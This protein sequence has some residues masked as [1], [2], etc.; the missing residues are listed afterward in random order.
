M[1]V[2]ATIL[3][4]DFYVDT[5]KGLCQGTTFEF[6]AWVINMDLPRICGGNPILPNITFNIET[7]TGTV[8]QTINSGIIPTN[9][10]IVWKQY[11]LYFQT[12]AGISDVVIRMKNNAPG[13]CGND[14]ALDDITFRPCGPLINTSA[15]GSGNDSVIN[16]CVGDTSTIVLT[17]Q[18]SGGYNSPQYQWQVSTDSGTA[19]TDIP[20]A[21]S[22][23]Y[24]RL[25][26]PAGKYLYR[27]AVAQ[28]GNIG[29]TT[30]RVASTPITV[31]VNPNPSPTLVNLGPKCAGSVFTLTA[32][33]GSTYTWTGP[34]NFTDTGQ[35]ITIANA[36]NAAHYYVN[37][38][39]IYGC[40]A[41]DSTV[42]TVYAN[43]VAKF[44]AATPDCE[45]KAIDFTDQSNVEP[46]ETI[47]QLKWLFGDGTSS[48]VANPQHT[49]S[50]ATSYSDS[51]IVTT[52]KGCTDTAVQTLTVHYLPQPAFL[53]PAVCLKDPFAAFTNTSTI[54]DSTE[55]GFIYLWNFG[56]PNATGADPNSSTLANPQHSYT[57]TGVYNV[58]L[59]VT[60][61]NGCAKDTIEPFTVNGAVPKA[62]FTLNNGD[63]ICSNTNLDIT[64]TSTVNFGSITKVEV[65]WDY[66]NDT[67]NN[68]TDFTTKQGK[69][70]S[71]KYP[72]FD[73]PSSKNY[74]IKY[75]AASGINC[76]SELDTV[77]TIEASPLLGFDTIRPICEGLAPFTL[78][79]ASENGGIGGTA[80][81]SG[82]GVDSSG[83]F[84]PLQAGLGADTIMYSFTAFD[85]CTAAV[86]RIV[87]VIAQPTA[88]AGPDGEL[89]QGGSLTIDGNA[90]GNNL[91]YL[92]TPDVY[93][94]GDST[95]MPTV[96]PPADITY[97]LTVTSSDGCSSKDSM[98]VM[99]LKT[100]L[101]PNAFSP[102]GDGINDRWM[103]NYLN[104]YANV[105]VQVF[106]RYGQQVFSSTG[107]NNPWDGTLN[108]TPLPVGTYYY[109]ID[110][111]VAGA[112]I[113]TGWV[114]IVR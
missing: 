6:A 77:V 48:T 103:I 87:Q 73:N 12:P 26:T 41:A 82:N 60:S 3:P 44:F 63:S 88:D 18:A 15:N 89:L 84:T 72:A 68:T 28:S 16:K 97:T 10:S 11:G 111:K 96:S 55:S 113:L 86:Q 78:T 30:C 52:D 33:G 13:G 70:Y 69:L 56:D 21:T 99:V 49:F 74:S 67:T 108:G 43:P 23:T 8:L 90:T 83:L 34:N 14:I 75:I 58:Q 94:F 25:A 42:L 31:N 45:N 76:V 98:N 101:I 114:A 54:Q 7:T 51:L 81:Y 65:Y 17:A 46:R 61:N 112:A 29:I 32:G 9:D 50:Q 92:W 22:N 35:T 5:V 106:N 100:P 62:G 91:T 36:I 110:R 66:A 4:S 24:Y 38:T 39:N 37:V 1:L 57:A 40:T 19:W 109:I 71:T 59:T 102:N 104:S 64:N 80:F 95:L 27:M 93:I 79:Q 107:Y 2:N 47:N 53:L 85:G 20:G 105:T